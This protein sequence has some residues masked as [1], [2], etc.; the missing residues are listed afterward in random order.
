[1]L[2]SWVG[3]WP[4]PQTLDLAG[5][6]CQGQTLWLI[7]NIVNYARKSLQNIGPWSVS[8]K[9]SNVDWLQMEDNPDQ[10][11]GFPRDFSIDASYELAKGWYL[12]NYANR[13]V[14][15]ILFS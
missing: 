9:F 15:F 6:A 14:R 4:H 10:L 12:I 1:M 7:T 8:D 3:S 2:H 5:K 11:T 13:L